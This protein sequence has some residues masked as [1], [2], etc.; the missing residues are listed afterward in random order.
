MPSILPMRNL[1]F[2]VL[3]SFS[4]L[5]LSSTSVIAQPDE[6]SSPLKDSLTS[7]VESFEGEVGIAVKHIPSGETVLIN[8]DE[9]MPTASLIK[10]SIMI[11]AYRQ[12]EAGKLDLATLITLKEED[13][14]PGSGVL[15]AHFSPGMQLSLR[16]AIRL[17][18]AYSDNTATNLVIDQVGLKS[19]SDTMEEFGF[20]ETKIH[21]K[22]YR[23]SSTTIFPE[24]SKKY[25]LG[26][27]TARETMSILEKLSQSEFANEEFNKEMLEHMRKCINQDR[28][29]PFL[30]RRTVVAQKTGSISTAR[31]VAGIIESPSGPIVV[32][33]LTAKGNRDSWSAGKTTD[34]FMASISKRAFDHF[35]KDLIPDETAPQ[36][37]RE[38]ATGWLVEALQRTLNDR[39]VPSPDLAVDG[40]F[41][42]S[43]KSA[44]M[45]FQSSKDLQA[46]GVAD[47]AV[48]KALGPLITSDL[49]I[50]NPDDFDMKL[51][52]KAE[53]DSLEGIPFVTC[54]AWI[55]GD[56]DSG[57][58][59]GSANPTRRLENASTTKLMTA[60][61]TIQQ[62]RKDPALL[63]EIVTVTSRAA[64]TPGSTAKVQTGEKLTIHDL[65][66]GLLLPS[67]NDA[68]VV[69]AEHLGNR[70]KAPEEDAETEDPL[71][72]FV[73][74]M[75]RVA[76][77]LGM[78][79]TQFRNPHGLSHKE[80]K[81]TVQDLFRL[82]SA[83][84]EDGMLLPYVQTRKHIGR[85]EGASG[86]VRYEL[87]TNS[88]QLLNID[89]YLGMKTG[90][91]RP[92]GA[93]LVSFGERD[94]QK[95]I[96]I[97]LGATSSDARYTDTRNLFRWA[98][99]ELAK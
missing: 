65:L 73:A 16:D 51:R 68:S 43:T 15:T 10:I 39:M 76:K 61:I 66:Y 2:A 12:V 59:I 98:W 23:G 79:N 8:A 72:K 67:G 84:A 92:A 64:N 9:A 13:K 6:A 95:L 31:T 45:D 80:H 52:K 49:V 48:W 22:V 85:L 93:C 54:K 42:P 47:A 41:G 7:L 29:P 21:S 87:W 37:L 58:I 1:V 27:T 50:T 24:R 70:F 57:K 20:P 40:D 96:T 88:N 30:P 53:S 99:N 3:F 89:G 90:T 77:K 32:V 56:P 83:I 71:V 69:L 62:V 75:N 14:V 55:V 26:S 38:G 44:V 34:L 60:Y 36:E 25:G 18:M 82:A 4:F 28:I 46:S 74:E 11:E 91:T 17:M 35:N 81:T 19:V 94:N 78:G 33:V 86:Y 5:A 63:N 97:V